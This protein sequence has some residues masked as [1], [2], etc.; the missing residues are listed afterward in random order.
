MQRLLGALIVVA[1]FLGTAAPASAANPPWPGRCPQKIVMVL[2]LS[3]SIG[4]NLPEVKHAAADLVDALRGAPNQLAVVAFGSA[5]TVAIPLLDAG[6]DD[7]RARLKAGVDDVGLVSGDGGGTN[8]EAAFQVTR[9]LQ[10]D[11]VLFLTDGEPTVHGDPYSGAGLQQGP[12]DLAPAVRI[13]DAM[14]ADGV[15]IV[16]L[17][18]GLTGT[19]L[20]NLVS[21]T[22]PVE[23]EDHYPTTATAQALLDRLYDIT[24]KACGIPVAALPQ[25][26][27][28]AFP[29]LEVLGGAVAAVLLAIVVGLLISRR[30][31]PGGQAGPVAAS[32]RAPLPPASIRLDDVPA[33]SIGLVGPDAGRGSALPDQVER[34]GGDDGRIPPPSGH[35]RMSIRRYQDPGSGGTR[36]DL[37]GD[38]PA[39]DDSPT[40]DQ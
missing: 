24:S 32:P 36:R 37:E 4:A 21:V 26:E 2:D 19:G 22:G 28:T 15:R 16:G 10:P 17:G 20:S 1:T 27:G 12:D 5:A 14:K 9:S 13:A 34:E 30:S 39:T 29:L 3:S 6:D 18:V 33:P 7:Q 25:P 8:W 11:L 40:N 23:G 31:R 35:R 38:Q